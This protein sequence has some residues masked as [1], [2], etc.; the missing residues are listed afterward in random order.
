MLKCIRSS[1]GYL[2]PAEFECQW[3]AQR[4]IAELTTFT[5]EFCVQG[6]GRSIVHSI[7]MCSLKWTKDL[8]RYITFLSI[9]GEE[10]RSTLIIKSFLQHHHQKDI[11][12]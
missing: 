9:D 4:Q 8:F 5:S 2:A 12:I 6:F 1:L 11:L 10:K 3:Q 7:F